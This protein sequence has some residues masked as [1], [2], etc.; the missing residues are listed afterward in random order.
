MEN[1]R[2]TKTQEEQWMVQNHVFRI[3]DLVFRLPPHAQS[4]KLASCHSTAIRVL[5]LRISLL[6]DF[7]VVGSSLTSNF[8]D[9]FTILFWYVL[10]CGTGSFELRRDNHIEYLTKSLK[11]LGPNF[12]VLDAKYSLSPNL[13]I[14]KVTSGRKTCILAVPL[15]FSTEC[16]CMCVSP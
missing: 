5:S 10:N 15:V 7:F 8:T 1:I 6:V 2:A 9:S 16:V 12:T 14:Y 4:V 3:Y 13:F 11:Q